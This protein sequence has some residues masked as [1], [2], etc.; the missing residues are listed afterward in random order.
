MV[1]WFIISEKMNRSVVRLHHYNASI[2]ITG[3]IRGTSQEKLHQE[4]GLESL[5]STGW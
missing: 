3:A 2:A 4:L 5:R 1:L